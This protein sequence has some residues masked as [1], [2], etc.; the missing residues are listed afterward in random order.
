MKI[1]TILA[2]LC[3]PALAGAAE[4]PVPAAYGELV[5]DLV[6]N[7]E[8]G[9]KV[10]VANFAYPDGGASGDGVVVS[11]RLTTELVGL[12]KFRVTERAEIEKVLAELKLQ[13]S[14]AMGADTI[15]DMGKML[16]ADWMIVGTLTGLSRG[17]IEVNARLV[18]VESGEIISAAAAKIKKDW[19]AQ[20]PAREPGENDFRKT[21]ELD[22]YGKAIHK[23][24]SEKAG[25]EN[26]VVKDPPPAF[27]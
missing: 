25:E 13:S 11:E 27:K 15:K 22:E 26:H 3:L 9:K 19:R 5:R 6:K 16:G 10:A 1:F 2:L 8:P 7:C 24:I 12:K 4:R 20:L 23:Y 17:R 21:D 18:G 14:G